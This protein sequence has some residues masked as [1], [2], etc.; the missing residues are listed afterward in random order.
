MDVRVMTQRR[1]QHGEAL[2]VGWERPVADPRW[3]RGA[4]GGQVGYGRGLFTGHIP[5][6]GLARMQSLSGQD[7]WTCVGACGSRRFCTGESVNRL[8]LAGNV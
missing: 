4:S 3:V 6:A 2:L 7:R 1:A 5:Y 8:S